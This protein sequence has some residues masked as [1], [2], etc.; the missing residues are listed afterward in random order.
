MVFD[1][2][3]IVIACRAVTYIMYDIVTTLGVE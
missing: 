2:C 1:E 3:S